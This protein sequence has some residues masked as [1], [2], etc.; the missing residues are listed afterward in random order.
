MLFRHFCSHFRDFPFASMEEATKCFSAIFAV[1]FVTSLLLPWRRPLN[2]FQPFLQSHFRN[3]PLASMEEA[4]KCFSAIF[5]ES[6][7]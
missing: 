4:T 1:T 6:L 7:S 3:F 5:E 2:A